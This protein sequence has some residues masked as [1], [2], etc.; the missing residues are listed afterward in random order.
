MDGITTMFKLP[1][2]IMPLALLVIA[3]PAEQ[4]YIEDRND[5]RVHYNNF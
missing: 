4:L 2:N 1:S 5:Y 3:Y